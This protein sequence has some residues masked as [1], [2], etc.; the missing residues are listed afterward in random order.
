MLQEA[1]RVSANKGLENYSDSKRNIKT[2]SSTLY[3]LESEN[4]FAVM[5]RNIF[6]RGHE[7]IAS[8]DEIWVSSKCSRVA[9]VCA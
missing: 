6:L 7:V 3:V 1:E 4:I 5:N 2:K 8:L 9:S